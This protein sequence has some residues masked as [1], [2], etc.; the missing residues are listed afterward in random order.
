MVDPSSTC[1]AVAGRS[2]VTVTGLPSAGRFVSRMGA[3]APPASVRVPP[4][5]TFDSDPYSTAPSSA[6]LGVSW[7]RG[8]GIRDTVTVIRGVPVISVRS[9]N[10]WEAN[11]AV[12]PGSPPTNVDS[13]VEASPDS[14]GRVEMEAG[15]PPGGLTTNC[16]S[17]VIGMATRLV[18]LSAASPG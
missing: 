13:A 15:E 5:E 7:H 2:T 3:T 10:G 4:S 18:L 9:S 11:R 1:R 8:R 12:C 17:P 14:P 16:G 6:V